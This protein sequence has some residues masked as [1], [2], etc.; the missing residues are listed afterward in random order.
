MYYS[1]F[2]LTTRAI[3]CLNGELHFREGGWHLESHERKISTRVSCLPKAMSLQLS[4]N[5]KRSLEQARKEGI[6]A[7]LAPLGYL[8]VID[9]QGNKDV[10]PDPD[11]RH[12]DCQNV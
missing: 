3:N 2:D 1:R 6:R 4:D 12:L 7:N 9:K 5:V 10:V 11:Q 8:N